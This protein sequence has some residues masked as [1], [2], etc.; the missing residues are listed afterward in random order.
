MRFLINRTDALGDLMVSLPIV[1]RILSRD[2]QADIHLLV[3]PNI[4]PVLEGYEEINGLHLRGSD[5]DLEA[6]LRQLA[7]DAVLNLSHSDRAV[8]LA[9]KRVGVPVRVARA[10]GLDQIRASTHLIW[11]GRSGTGRHEAQ[12]V[13]DFLAPWGWS[14]GLPKAP[15]L[16]LNPAE[17]IQAENELSVAARPRL[18]LVLRGSGSGAYPSD[19]WWTLAIPAFERA[20]WNPVILAP[21][22]SSTLPVSD[23]RRLMARI[24][25]CDAVVSPSTGP[26]HLAGAL[27]VPLLCLMGLRASHR[28]DRWAPMGD[29][30]QVVQYPGPEADLAGGMDRL[31]P[32]TLVQH[33]ERFK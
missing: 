22:E 30:V 19:A 4:A 23:L 13:L 5:S 10:R 28:P 16:V 6:L 2:P 14:G 26:A 20:G 24:A 3:R 8:I 33:L 11:K 27:R 15:R 7:P 9:S 21:P 18:G 12:N 32:E 31:D 1:S 25:A 29:R 17:M